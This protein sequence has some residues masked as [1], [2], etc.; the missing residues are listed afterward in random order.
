MLHI[1][2]ALKSAVC[3]LLGMAV[4]EYKGDV[5]SVIVLLCHKFIVLTVKKWSK[6]VYI[7]GSYR[8]MKPRLPLFGPLYIRL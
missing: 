4:T 3:I 8:K 7:Y 2:N 1:R 5:T 6:L